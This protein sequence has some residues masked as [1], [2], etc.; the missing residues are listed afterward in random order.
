MKKTYTK[1]ESKK[2]EIDSQVLRMLSREG[3]VDVFWEELAFRQK[4]D[5]SVTREEVFSL[6]NEKYFKAL[7]TYRY[8]CYD[9]FRRRLNDK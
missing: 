6:L 8:S 3:F 5:P 1:P 7:G 9:S 2:I 4:E